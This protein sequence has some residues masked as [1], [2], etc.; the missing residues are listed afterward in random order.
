VQDESNGK[1]TR[2]VANRHSQASQGDVGGHEQREQDV[3]A[4]KGRP[5]VC[6]REGHKLDAVAH[7]RCNQAKKAHD[8]EP[9][10][11]QEDLLKTRLDN[12]AHKHDL[13]QS[14]LYNPFRHHLRDKASKTKQKTALAF[15]L[16]FYWSQRAEHQSHNNQSQQDQRAQDDV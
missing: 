15:Y 3:K 6:G 16:G 14:M 13:E 7:G 4:D 9:A 12:C 8:H 1:E 10:R 2:R 11:P 5:R